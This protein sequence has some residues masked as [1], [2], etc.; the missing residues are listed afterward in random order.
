MSAWAPKRFWKE[1]AVVETE[2]GYGI[3]LDGRAVKTPAK[4]PLVVPTRAMAEA[5]AAEWDA[6]D[7]L[8]KPETMPWTRS[9]N[10]AID[11]LSIQR[12]AV[13]DMLAEY[14]GSDLLCYRVD[15]PEELV[16]RQN[17]GWDPILLW[18]EET[19]GA[20]L[21]TTAGLM[22]IAQDEAAVAA[23]KAP[24]QELSNFELA[25]FHDLVAI[26]G[27]LVLALAVIKG[28]LTSAEAF[29]LSRMDE[30]FQIE[31]W[32]KDEEAAEIDAIKAEA[33]EQSRRFYGL[34]R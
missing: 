15:Q 23:L 20:K 8:I 29:A 14:G 19:F 1:A 13:I 30:T 22:P 18:A 9:A 16:S 21:K 11:K 24:I 6:Q 28:R 27:S 17:K 12:Q 32:G 33:Y 31:Q 25:A 34:C 2:G 5:I 7:G 3:S 26:S 10:S 4:A